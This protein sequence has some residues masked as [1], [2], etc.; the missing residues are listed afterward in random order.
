VAGD[1]DRRFLHFDAS[2]QRLAG[3][4]WDFPTVVRGEALVCRGIYRLKTSDEAEVGGAEPAIHTMFAERLAAMGLDLARYKNKR[5]AERGFDPVDRVAKGPWMLVGEA[6]GIDPVTG[7][8][9]AQAIEFGSLAGPFVARVLRG[10]AAI[11]DWPNVVKQSRLAKDLGIR[12]RVVRYFYG[13][14]RPVVERFVLDSPDF[15]YVGC[16][17]FA[18][19]PY[20]R[21][22]LAGV[23]A[24]LGVRYAALK[25]SQALGAR[26]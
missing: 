26:W 5:Y 16:Q 1:R 4:T 15:L 17:H 2:D 22:K 21:A 6:A 20:D 8:G 3:Y 19:Q 11:E 7:E 13:A 23:V 24:R 18:A 10:E 25:I 9:I 14:P 12:T